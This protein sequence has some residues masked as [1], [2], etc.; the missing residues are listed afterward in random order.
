M[1][2]LEAVRRGQ[3]KGGI[4]KARL[5]SAVHTERARTEADLGGAGRG[6][7]WRCANATCR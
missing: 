7:E 2:N 4:D 1:F 5:A 6:R 3:P